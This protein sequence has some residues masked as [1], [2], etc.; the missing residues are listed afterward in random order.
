MMTDDS[1]VKNKKILFIL[2]RNHAFKE[3]PTVERLYKAG[4]KLATFTF[5]E[6]CEKMVSTQDRVK[7]ESIL[8]HSHIEKNA[9]E[10]VNK[11]NYT[12]E[13]FREDYDISSIYKHASSLRRKVTSYEKKYPF[14][15][16]QSA[17]D[18]EI[19]DYILAFG[20]ELK[21]FFYN[22]KP[23]I[24][25][26]Y[27][28]GSIGYLMLEKLCNKEKVPY[29][30][31][32]D[33][34]I[35]DVSAFFYNTVHSKSFFHQRIKDLN[36]KKVIS[37]NKLK[38]KN[39]VQ[40]YLKS[41]EKQGFNN[42]TNLLA[43]PEVL[44]KKI[45]N[46]TDIK[47]LLRNLYHTFK[48][49]NIRYKPMDGS[50]QTSFIYDLR[51]YIYKQKNIFQVG[52]I[53]F[54]KLE[55]I[56]NF[57]YM[58][59]GLYPETQLGMLNNVYDN[60]INTAR[61][62][63]RFL[64]NNLKLVV[65]DHPR[66]FSKNSKSFLLKLQN[67]PNVKLIDHKTLNDDIYKKMKYLISFSGTSIFEACMYKKPALQ[68][69]TLE[70]MNDL[71]NFYLLN[72]IT[73]VEEVISEIDQNFDKYSKSEDYENKLINYVSAAYDVGFSTSIYESKVQEIAEHQE[74]MYKVHLREIKKIFRYK[75]KFQF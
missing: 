35:D 59:L 40:N 63:A 38:A 1:F 3:F 51:D 39:Y 8:K 53:K 75:D 10:I 12:F 37:K 16:E 20:F 13:N 7:F 28:W 29:Y 47:I 69:G 2:Q 42:L 62:L 31:H 66:A 33:T 34:K 46:F 27:I 9:K 74:Y 68:I 55:D 73:K 23:D 24:C 14:S 4:A 58:P 15:F 57:V 60:Q 52:K 18:Q 25:I 54:D 67:S 43:E 72:D 56:D 36:N 22:F 5:K 48:K 32:S 26:G 41:P 44:D 19:E 70:V 6:T 65:K 71:P 21:N 50:D 45:F 61:I 30:N 17:T 49:S 11:N 64:P